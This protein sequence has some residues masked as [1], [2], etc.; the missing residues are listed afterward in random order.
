MTAV[1]RGV[2]SLGDGMSLWTEAG[3]PGER[4]GRRLM[5]KMTSPLNKGSFFLLPL[6]SDGI[7]R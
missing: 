7:M 2:L 1:S 4:R 5:P 3:E 6:P